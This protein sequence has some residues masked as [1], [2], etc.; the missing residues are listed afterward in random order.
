MNAQRNICGAYSIKSECNNSV[1]FHQEMKRLDFSTGRYVNHHI[2][3]S[4]HKHRR[5]N[6][7]KTFLFGENKLPIYR[8]SELTAS[9]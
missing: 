8:L 6:F 4:L 5:Q 1:F 3:Y 2:D 7:H 9:R